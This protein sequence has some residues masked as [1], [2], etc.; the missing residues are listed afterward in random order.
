MIFKTLFYLSVEGSQ[1]IPQKG[2]FILASNHLSYL[3]PAVL[4]AACRRKLNFMARDDLFRIPFFGWFIRRTGAFPVKRNSA[5]RAALKEA[6]R[7]LNAG[8]ALSLFP[9]GSRSGDGTFS[10]PQPGIGFL[11]AKL[12]CPVIPVFIKGTDKAFPKGAKFIRRAKISVCF[13]KQITIE[14]GLPYQDIALVIMEGIK[15][16]S[17]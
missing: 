2:G 17:C 3:D 10:E 8:K 16:L 9:E 6:T 7:R 15:H 1:N 14:R 13:G 12:K 4:G 5:D 11:A